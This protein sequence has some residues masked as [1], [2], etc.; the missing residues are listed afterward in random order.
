MPEEV[1]A[2]RPLVTAGPGLSPG[3]AAA[4][5]SD[6]DYS[7]PNGTEAL[8][9]L[10]LAI[11]EG[12]VTAIVGP[13]G[14]GKSTMLQILSELVGPTAGTVEVKNRKDGRHK[15]SMVFQYDTLL[16]WLTVR[17]NVGLYY[18]FHRARRKAI[19]P[20]IDELL[21]MVKLKQFADAYPRQLSG[22]M[23]RRV[24]FLCGVASE[25]Q[26]LLLDE[27]FSSVDEPTR[28]KIHQ[29]VLGIVRESQMTTVLVTHDLAEAISLSHQVVILTARPGRVFAVHEIPFGEERDVLSLR[30][31]P[32][33]LEIYGRLWHDLSGQIALADLDQPPPPAE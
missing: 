10:S 16:P 19:Q 27:P 9:G 32:E 8:K 28:V 20:R 31:Q 25:P 30:D 1:A 7:Y 12:K 4:V 2:L 14:C 22:G 17:N 21:E 23:R 3:P 5:F 33:F 29:D 13:S 15:L 26:I 18:R 24:A 6:V 11:P